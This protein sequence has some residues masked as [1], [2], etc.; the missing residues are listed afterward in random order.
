M[1]F[2]NLSQF[3]A[4]DLVLMLIILLLPLCSFV[5]QIFFGRKLPRQ[6]DWLATMNISICLVLALFLFVKMLMHDGAPEL[7]FGSDQVASVDADGN[8]ITENLNPTWIDITGF[9]IK[10]GIL[11]DNLTAIMLVVVTLVSTLV[12]FFSIGYMH[13]DPRYSRYFGYLGLFSF[14]MLGLVLSDNLLFLYVFWELVGVSSFLLIGFWFEKPSAAAACVKAFIT[15]RVG[16]F[17]FFL[18]IAI[19]FTAFGVLGYRELFAAL[20]ADPTAGGALSAGLLTAAGVL[21]FMG[22]VGKSAQM[23][24]HVWLPDAMEGPTPVSALIHAAT[25]VAAGVYLVGRLFVVFTP[26]ALLVIALV[27][28][29]TAI[30][31]AFLGIVMNDIKKVLAYSTI[32]QLGYMIAAVGVGAVTAG[33]FHLMTH[34]FFKALLFLGSGS[35]IYGMH[36]HQDM[37]EMGGLR[38]KMPITF[39]TMFIATLAISGVPLLSGFLSKDMIL[40]GALYRWMIPGGGGADWLYALPFLFLLIAAGVTAFYMFR[41][42]CLTFFGETKSEHADHAHESPKV[43]TVPLI[44]LAVLAIASGGIGLTADLGIGTR[45]FQDHVG[46]PSLAVADTGAAFLNHAE[47]PHL[48][49]HEEHAEHSSHNIAMI[50]SLIVAASGIFLALAFYVW[51]KLSAAKVA[52]ALSPVHKLLE[53]KYYFDN[54]YIGVLCKKVIVGGLNRFLWWFDA[55]IIDGIVNLTARI[56]RVLAAIQGLFDKIVVDG[57]VNLVGLVTIVWGFF[58]QRLQTGRIQTY[59]MMFLIGFVGLAA[60]FLLIG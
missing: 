17:G 47:P 37:R 25:M 12:H 38:K 42:I 33:L 52:A 2:F 10:P 23:P 21:L 20:A 46:T 13:G 49:E 32:S 50:C 9:V 58:S 35:V 14:S 19:L 39:W 4:P 6:G 57:L 53:N 51:K 36:H 18:G 40:A 8:Q 48:T 54:V 28:A 16:D 60:A 31:A 3:G 26:E 7:A 1:D 41:L 11:F 27:G 29:T 59:L 15:N 34:A 24:L 22:A 56:T 43:M 30:F 44:I 5:I 55:T 45:W